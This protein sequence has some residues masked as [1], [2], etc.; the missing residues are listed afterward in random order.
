MQAMKPR[1]L[2]TLERLEEA[3]PFLKRRSLPRDELLLGKLDRRISRREPAGIPLERHKV[4][5]KPTTGTEF[6]RRRLERLRRATPCW[7]DEREITRIY[8][9]AHRLTQ[10]TGTPYVVD[11]FYPLAGKTV[12]GLHVHFNLRVITHRE[13]SVKAA[14]VIE[15]G[16]MGIPAL[17]ASSH[18][19]MGRVEPEIA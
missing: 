12:S 10:E 15:E 3:Y 4:G 5:Y 18:A 16:D 2:A 13:N 1:A 14:K 8:M 6:S 7:A 17:R 9:E 11:H 19:G